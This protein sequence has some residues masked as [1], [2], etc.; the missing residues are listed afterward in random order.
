MD[1]SDKSQSDKK[2]ARREI[3]LAVQALADT[4]LPTRDEARRAYDLA[5]H[6][7]EKAMRAI[8]DTT[9]LDEDQAVRIVATTLAFEFVKVQCQQRG[10][11]MALGRP[12]LEI[13]RAAIIKE[14]EA[15]SDGK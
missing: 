12:A 1:Q 13:R 2:A 11:M 10:A 3:D 7:G 9:S 15:Q 6:A 5:F 4:V 8:T 14:R